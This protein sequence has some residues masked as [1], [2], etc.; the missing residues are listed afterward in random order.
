MYIGQL[1]MVYSANMFTAAPPTLDKTLTSTAVDVIYM[2][3]I[4]LCAELS[5]G[6]HSCI[7]FISSLKIVLTQ[8]GKANLN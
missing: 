4:I 5:W 1:D 6:K 3:M 2:Y 7:C 8:V